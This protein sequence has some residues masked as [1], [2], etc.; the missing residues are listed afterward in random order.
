IKFLLRGKNPYSEDYTQTPMA[1]WGLDYKTALYHYPYLPWTFLFSLPFFLVSNAALGWFDQRL[2]YLI[3]FSL[4]LLMAARLTT[5][6]M[7]RLSLVMILGLNPIMGSDLIFG[8]NDAFV[9][10]WIIAAL[11]AA[12]QPTGWARAAALALFALACASK[13]TAWFVAP[14]FLL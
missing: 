12:R 13:P 14:F 6:P 1:Q 3:L 11:F 8:Q 5:N 4:T 7:A 9:L 2:V 10:C